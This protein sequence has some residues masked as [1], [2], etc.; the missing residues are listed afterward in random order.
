MVQNKTVKQILT[1]QVCGLSKVSTLTQTHTHV[2]IKIE[3]KNTESSL[4]EQTQHAMV[5][6]KFWFFSSD[7]ES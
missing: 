2:H 4:P 1:R 5:L 3:K 7:F 6:T